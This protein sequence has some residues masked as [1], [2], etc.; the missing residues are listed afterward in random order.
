TSAN[1]DNAALTVSGQVY[2]ATVTICLNV[3][4]YA[5]WGLYSNAD[6][7]VLIPTNT[8]PSPSTA[9]VKVT[10]QDGTTRVYTLNVLLNPAAVVD[11]VNVL[12]IAD[13]NDAAISTTA[14]SGTV[15]GS[16]DS[17]L[18][19]PTLSGT[20]T[21]KLYL[22]SGLTTECNPPVM[23]L[24][25]GMNTAYLEVTAGGGTKVYTLTV[26]RP[27][28]NADVTSVGGAY[29]VNSSS[30]P[31]SI[32]KGTVTINTSMTVA[33]F[34]SNLTK[35]A[36]AVWNV[37]PVGTA[38]NA[39]SFGSPSAKSNVATMMFGDILAV[40]AADET[41]KTYNIAVELGDPVLAPGLV[42]PSAPA[43]LVI[44]TPSGG[45]I[46]GK[47][48]YFAYKC[49]D[50]DKAIALVAFDNANNVIGQWR[51]TCGNNKMIGYSFDIKNQTVKVLTS[52]GNG[53]SFKYSDIM[54][55]Q[56]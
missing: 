37:F 4:P 35:D 2:L 36:G 18:I 5:T 10:A 53:A 46:W 49:L 55:A 7:S 27:S 34:L 40:K 21:W 15:A 52:K 56:P 3:S 48:K 24:L 32:A 51:K 20:A 22:D 9:Y 23:I 38:I 45:F 16:V 44:D 30:V 47:Y 26:F 31:Y 33:V 6:C 50:D 41:I 11:P 25:P 13:L 19:S 17:L 39:D 14:I 54:I 42:Q 8:L 28:N 43:G 29:L 12:A 1:I